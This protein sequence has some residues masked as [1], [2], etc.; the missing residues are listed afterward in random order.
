VYFWTHDLPPGPDDWDGRVG[1]AENVVPLAD[2]FAAFL[3]GIAPGG[4]ADGE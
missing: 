2:T 1:T 4:P 3:A